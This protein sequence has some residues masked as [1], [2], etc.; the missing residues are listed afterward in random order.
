MIEKPQSAVRA[1]GNRSLDTIL[2]LVFLG[3]L[4]VLVTVHCPFVAFTAGGRSAT[5]IAVARVSAIITRTAVV[6]PCLPWLPPAARPA[7]RLS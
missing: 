2:P 1:I 7:L 6:V 5:P 3:L 4:M